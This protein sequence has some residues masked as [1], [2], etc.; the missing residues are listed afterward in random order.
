M[1]RQHR[2]LLAAWMGLLL[3]GAVEYGCSLLS[4]NRALRPILLLPALLMVSVVALA[5]MHVRHGPGVNRAFALAG[6]FWLTVL[7]GLGMMDP[8]TRAIYA[9][10]G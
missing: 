5:F 1:S 8:L 10:S 4:F 7:L 3:L 6:L 2:N 9:V